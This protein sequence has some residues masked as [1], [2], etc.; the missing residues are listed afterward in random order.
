[1]KSI[2]LNSQDSSRINKGNPIHANFAPR[3]NSRVQYRSGSSIEPPPGRGLRTPR[4][5]SNCS[6]I[7]VDRERS[8]SAASGINRQ[9]Y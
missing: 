6:T 9:K 2:L 8:V 3:N 7:S 5:G 1:M 4:R